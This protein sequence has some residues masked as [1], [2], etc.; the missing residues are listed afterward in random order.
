VLGALGTG[1]PLLL[2]HL[3]VA[4]VLLAAGVATYLA[5]TPFN[6]PRLMRTGN[7]AA[8]TVLAGA[9]VALAVPLAILVATT[10]ATLDLVVWGVVAILLQ[11]LTFLIVS[12]L[13]G[14]LKPMVEAGQVAGA[15]P[16]VA[17]QLAVALLNAGAMVPT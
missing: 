5:I 7:V 2:L 12:R 17:A 4:L 9:V 13:I 14:Q 8:A 6:E 15:I 11:L 3:G 10:V 1:L 16:L